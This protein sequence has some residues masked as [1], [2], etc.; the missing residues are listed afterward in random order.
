MTIL[1]D[2]FLAALGVVAL[3]IG[4]FAYGAGRWLP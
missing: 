4:L 3:T 2:I 1:A